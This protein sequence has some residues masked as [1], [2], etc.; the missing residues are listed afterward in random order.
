VD[1]VCDCGWPGPS[2]SSTNVRIFEYNGEILYV[3]L[4]MQDENKKPMEFYM[5]VLLNFSKK[6]IYRNLSESVQVLSVT[7]RCC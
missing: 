5:F 1:L 7:S 6:G 2:A 4:K 3:I